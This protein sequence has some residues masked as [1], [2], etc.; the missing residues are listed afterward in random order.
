MA[1]TPSNMLPLGTIAPDFTL[2]DA[3]SGHSLSLHSLK[4]PIATV[5]FFTCNHCPFVKHIINELVT[6][7]HQYQAKGISFIAINSND[8]TRYSE[9]SPE[10]M[11]EFAT[12][13]DFKFPYLFDETQAIAHAYQAAC[14]PDFY[15]F[16]SNLK[17]VYRGRF[18]NATPGTD[19]PVTGKDLRTALDNILTHQP[20]EIE[21]KP[22][23][24]CNIKWK[25]IHAENN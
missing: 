8:V 21:Q 25:E 15:I 10:K 16:D 23:I 20:I 4:S 7:A 22:S 14:T 11:K 19:V 12:D 17:C 9:D 2:M 5:I 6:T 1:R 24:G 13:H 3:I 18:D